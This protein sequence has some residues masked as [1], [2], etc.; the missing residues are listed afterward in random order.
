MDLRQ[1]TPLGKHIPSPQI[2]WRAL[3]ITTVVP[4]R[5]VGNQGVIVTTMPR[6]YGQEN[7]RPVRLLSFLLDHT[8]R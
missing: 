2:R 6:I 1:I 8:I 3:K 7:D 5:T 4:S